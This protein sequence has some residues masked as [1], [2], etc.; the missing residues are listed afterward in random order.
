MLPYEISSKNQPT[1]PD[2]KRRPTTTALCG[3]SYFKL[4]NGCS[5]HQRLG[6]PTNG[7]SGSAAKVE[8]TWVVLASK[9]PL[10]KSEL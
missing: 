6:C 3:Y 4:A 8:T 2:N 9:F 7:S 1:L 10:P 5:L